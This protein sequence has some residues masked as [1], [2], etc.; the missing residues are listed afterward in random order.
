[1]VTAKNRSILTSHAPEQSLM[2]L[3]FTRSGKFQGKE[4]QAGETIKCTR[5][6]ARRLLITDKSMFKVSMD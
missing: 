1:M 6:E 3:E 2:V 4:Y 5:S